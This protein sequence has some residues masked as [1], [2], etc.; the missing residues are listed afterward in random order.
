VNR[1]QVNNMVLR[2]R[3]EYISGAMMHTVTISAMNWRLIETALG[4]QRDADYRAILTSEARL[5]T[6]DSK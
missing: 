1:S 3:V 4:V 6:A 2:R 5:N